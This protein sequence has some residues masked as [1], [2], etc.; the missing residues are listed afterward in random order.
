MPR[1]PNNNSFY[2]NH[3]HHVILGLMMLIVLLMIAVGALLYQMSHR[4]L[5]TFYALQSNGQK[6]ELVPSQEP[7]LLP[8]TIIRWA[9]KA[10]TV[11]YTFDF[12]NYSKQIAAA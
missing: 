10:A 1:L 8:D 4:P 12:V 7:N 6:M 2:C 5:P 9:S 11:A 3:Y